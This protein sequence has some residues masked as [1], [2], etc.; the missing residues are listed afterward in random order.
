MLIIITA[1]GSGNGKGVRSTPFRWPARRQPCSSLSCCLPPL[2]GFKGGSSHPFGVGPWTWEGWGWGQPLGYRNIPGARRHS[3]IHSLVFFHSLWGS[4]W[5]V[6][7]LKVKSS[8]PQRFWVSK[9][10]VLSL[11]VKSSELQRNPLMGPA[12]GPSYEASEH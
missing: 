2:G 7:N 12:Q 3:F 9:W 11:R 10:K 8:E 5:K 6:L 1:D 4:K